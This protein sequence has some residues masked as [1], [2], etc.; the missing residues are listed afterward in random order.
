MMFEDP[1]AELAHNPLVRAFAGHDATFTASRRDALTIDEAYNLSGRSRTAMAWVVEQLYKLHAR[2]IAMTAES[3]DLFAETHGGVLVDSLHKPLN[4]TVA[5]A[6]RLAAAGQAGGSLPVPAEVLAAYQS[7]RDPAARGALC[8]APVSSLYFGANG[9]VTTCCFGRSEPYGFWPRSS[10]H[11]IWFGPKPRALQTAMA[12]STLPRLC[13]LCH[14][15]ML[16]QNFR[17][18]LA[19]PY[20]GLVP[21]LPRAVSPDGRR[22]PV[23][24]E[25]EL[26]N[27]C[28]LEC[29]MC[30]GDLWPQHRACHLSDGQQLGGDARSGPVCQRAQCHRA[31]QHGGLAGQPVAPLV[32]TG[33]TPRHCRPLHQR[34]R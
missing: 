27:R 29:A 22:W 12:G 4:A 8:H 16:V 30:S 32:A 15:Q 34:S 21:L 13:K 17:N 14:D 23:K 26:S 11:E 19:A 2:E 1:P 33:S 6:M 5:H 28:N 7:Q 9:E 20:D 25:F 31:F 18:M 10:L 24:I 3:R